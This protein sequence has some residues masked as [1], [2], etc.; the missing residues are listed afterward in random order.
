MVLTGHRPQGAWTTSKQSNQKPAGEGMHRT[1]AA[2]GSS[3]SQPQGMGGQG[4]NQELPNRP[5]NPGFPRVQ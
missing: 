1:A 4:N 3:L 2:L 5:G